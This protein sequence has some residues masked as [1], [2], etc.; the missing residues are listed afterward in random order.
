M[1]QP[2]NATA[3]GGLESA[4]AGQRPPPIAPEPLDDE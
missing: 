1:L 4:H 2:A 3:G